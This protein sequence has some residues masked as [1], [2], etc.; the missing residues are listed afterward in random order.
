VKTRAAILIEAGKPM[1]IVE[2]E[3][4]SPGPTRYKLDEINETCAALNRGE[5]AGRAIIEL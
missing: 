3:L 5:I 2:V 4:P 1:I